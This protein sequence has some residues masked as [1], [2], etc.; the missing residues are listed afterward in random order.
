MSTLY[1]RI[2]CLRAQ[3]GLSL[4]DLAERSG[5]SRGYL[6]LLATGK[7]NLTIDKLE[8]IAAGLDT[9]AASLL[10]ESER[11]VLLSLEDDEFRAVMLMREGNYPA[12]LRL[13]ADEMTASEQEQS[14]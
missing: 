4:T 7:H 6:H 8:A 13:I 1:E 5:V 3:R 11:G 10:S 12:L 14:A 2:N 9:T